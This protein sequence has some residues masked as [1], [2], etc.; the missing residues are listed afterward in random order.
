MLLSR[1]SG[2]RRWTRLSHPS[3]DFV[4]NASKYHVLVESAGADGVYGADL[5]EYVLD[6][7]E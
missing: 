6:V 4:A 1:K 5:G 2:R 7:W 3:P